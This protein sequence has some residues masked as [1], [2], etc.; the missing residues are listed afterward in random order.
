MMTQLFQ[1]LTEIPFD[2]PGKIF[3]S[4]MP[5]SSF[6]GFGESWEL[7]LKNDI[8]TVVVLTEPREYLIHAGRNL[9]VF[10][11]MEGLDVIHYPIEDYNIPKDKS[12]LE[13]TIQ[14]VLHQLENGNNIVVHC[15]AGHGR[16]GIFLACLAKHYFDMSGVESVMWIHQYIPNALENEQQ[17][18]F[19]IDY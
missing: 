10:Y 18:K 8:D 3:R 13:D 19:V 2:L 6:D 12:G 14:K 1:L 9:P 17:K 15:M 4:P 7:F 5:F 16:T 11:Q